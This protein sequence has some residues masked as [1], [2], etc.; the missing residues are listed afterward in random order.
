MTTA[1]PIDSDLMLRV[2]EGE[3]ECFEYLL[4]RHR[5]PLVHFLYRM[6]H[7]H[8]VAEELAQ[9]VF[10]RVYC[11]RAN[12]K[13]SAKFTTWLYR[14]ATNLAL[15]WLRDKRHERMQESLDAVT[16]LG[17]RRQMA[18]T[19]PNVHTSMLKREYLLEIQQAIGLLPDRQKAAVL[20]HKYE[21]MDYWQI[22]EAMGCSMT[23]VKALLFRAYTTLRTRLAH[24]AA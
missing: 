21:E 15:N 24:V 9:E 7:N 22:A 8:G 17:F 14:I 3:I 5:T 12:Y 6:V 19:T 23:T 18:D 11:S 13:P 20:M 1:I 2:K 16:L 10:L 4:E